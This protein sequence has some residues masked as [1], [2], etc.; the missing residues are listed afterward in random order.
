MG[1]SRER[2]R[3]AVGRALKQVREDWQLSLDD[4]ERASLS[5][6]IRITRSHLSRVE[7]G[8]AD[9]ALPRFLT[10]MRAV[11]ETPARVVER[12][13]ALL[14]EDAGNAEAQRKDAAE[15]LAK[16]DP[17]RAARRLRQLHAQGVR[18]ASATLLDWARAEAALGRWP[19]AAEV[20]R[21]TLVPF[22]G[23]AS[24][25][26][27]PLAVATLGSGELGL[28]RPL[29]A[30]IASR[31]PDLARAVDLAALLANGQAREAAAGCSGFPE[32]A[33]SPPELLVRAE[34]FRRL[35][36]VQAAVRTAERVLECEP[37]EALA[38]ETRLALARAFGDHRRPAAGLQQIAKARAL[39]RDMGIPELLIRAHREAARLFRMAGKTEEGREA[40]RAARALERRHLVGME[41]DRALPLQGLF[42]EAWFHSRV[43]EPPETAVAC[44]SA[45]QVAE[46]QAQAGTGTDR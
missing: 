12:L 28:V 41:G 6:G 22:H 30:G 27:L 8:M 26:L 35:G 42:L 40:G 11:G 36:Q 31:L 5:E 21:R 2:L 15:A 33:A 46:P 45:L 39:A 19:A 9:L 18:L 14:D 10:L 44:A 13:D 24:G 1:V 29:V 32:Q 23:S 20:L 3:A 43:L 4:I 34:L 17:T 38:V 25:R 37:S 7:N 16:G